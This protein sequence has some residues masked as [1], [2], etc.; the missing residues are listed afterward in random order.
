MQQLRLV[1]LS[2]ILLVFICI[3]SV[4]QSAAEIGLVLRGGPG[5]TLATCEKKESEICYRPR[6]TF[7]NRGKYPIIIINPTLGYGSGIREAIF[8]YSEYSE[9]RKSIILVEGKRKPI[10]TSEVK[11]DIFKSTAKLF[12]S[13]QPPQNLTIILKPGE[14]FSFDESFV[15]EQDPWIPEKEFES[16]RLNHPISDECSSGRCRRISS[17]IVL[18]F[19]FSFL[20]YVS[21]PEFLEQLG[22]RWR[23]YGI[24][25]VDNNGNYKLVSEGF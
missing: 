11:R 9:D 23:P 25:P 1:L 19:E 4:A 6:M 3:P 13:D 7:E 20:P 5:V 14:T 24:F 2:F 12:E 8:L 17:K 15:V 16:I 18:V 21:D 10:A 22:K